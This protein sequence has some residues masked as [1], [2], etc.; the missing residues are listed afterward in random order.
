MN[1]HAGRQDDW[2][3]DRG[4]MPCG[5]AKT[6]EGLKTADAMRVLRALATAERLRNERKGVK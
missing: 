2:R 6:I 3:D 4:E 5:A 1:D